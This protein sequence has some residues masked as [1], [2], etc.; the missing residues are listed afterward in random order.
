MITVRA[1]MQD[2]GEGKGAPGKR[3]R[4]LGQR[5]SVKQSRCTKLG[6]VQVRRVYQKNQGGYVVDFVID[7]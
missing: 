3:L 5:K 6:F 1:A 2:E 7:E 4:S